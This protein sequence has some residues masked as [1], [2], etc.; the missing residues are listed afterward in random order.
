MDRCRISTS[1]N[2]NGGG[3]GGNNVGVATYALSDGRKTLPTNKLT[4]DD[5]IQPEGRFPANFI[6]E[7]TCDN[8]IVKEN[9]NQPYT[10]KDKNYSEKGFLPNVNAVAPYNY[11][12]TNSGVVH[13]DPNC[14]CYILDKQS[15]KL[16]KQAKCKTDNKSGWQNDY[17][18]GNG[19]N[20]VERKLYLDEGGASRFFYC[21]KA[22]KSDRNEGINNNHPTVK[23]TDLMTYLI[24]LVTPKDGIVLDPFMGSGSTGKACMREGFGFVGIEREEE[25]LQ[26]AEQRIEWEY[27]KQHPHNWF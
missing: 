9:T 4:K 25:Y 8:P 26:I 5:F 10:Y 7:C 1:D 16:N 17:V 2:L 20:A 13:T 27:N 24:R 21:P 11:N 12:D 14:P 23:P 18:G 15:G 22:N 6:L 19:V 3:Y